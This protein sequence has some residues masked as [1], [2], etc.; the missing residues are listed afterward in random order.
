MRVYLN[1]RIKLVFS[2]PN[3]KGTLLTWSKLFEFETRA[4]HLIRG[5][6]PTP[7]LLLAMQAGDIFKHSKLWLLARRR[8]EDDEDPTMLLFSE[9]DL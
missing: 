7:G 9:I 1:N 3:R 8:G 2:S 5:D 6:K 4:L